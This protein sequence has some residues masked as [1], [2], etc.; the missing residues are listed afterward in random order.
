[1]AIIAPNDVELTEQQEIAVSG[2][3]SF[4]DNNKSGDYRIGGYAGTGKTT[5]LKTLIAR[6]DKDFAVAALAGKAVDVLRRKG[7][8]QAKTVH[9]TIYKYEPATRTFHRRT[10]L[11]ADA[12]IVDEASMINGELYEDMLKFGI[13]LI[14]V[15]DMGQLEPIGSDVNLMN[16]ADLDVRLTEIMR[17]AAENPIIEFATVVRTGGEFW[18]GDFGTIKIGTTIDFWNN[19]DKVDKI[20]CGTNRT[21]H[22]VNARVRWNLGHAPN[23]LCVGDQLVCIQNNKQYRVFNGMSLSVVAIKSKT[24]LD[25]ICDLRTEDGQDLPDVP[26][27]AEQL[28]KD[29]DSDARFVQES[30]LCDYGYCITCHKAQG[31]EWDRVLVLEDSDAWDM[32]RWRYTAVTRAAKELIYCY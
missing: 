15:G 8:P 28:G 20:L 1:M 14:F 29:K 2:A 5:I 31:S 26:V 22:Q 19:I 21:R 17:Q 30:V 3:L 27:L 25:F 10:T 6:S 12:L 24:S 11:G 13:P 4:I 16:E 23:P 32:K 9:S 18:R 7:V